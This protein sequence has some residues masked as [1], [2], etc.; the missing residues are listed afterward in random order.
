MQTSWFPRVAAAVR[1][2]WPI[3]VVII[4]IGLIATLVTLLSVHPKYAATTSIL[5]VAS[6]E[7]S[8]ALA[9]APKK[10]LASIDLPSLV[11]GPTVL[12]RVR[13]DIAES[14]PIQMLESRVHT[15]ISEDSAIM[16]VSYSANTAVKA[17]EGAN[18]F[19]TEITR[20]YR[21]LATTRFDS[22]ISDLRTQLTTRRAELGKLDGDIATISQAYPFVDTKSTSASESG[23]S[24]NQRLI[25]LQG[26]REALQA[27]IQAD[28]AV[29]R[30]SDRLIADA[31]PLAMRDVI[32]SD[33]VY[34]HIRD[35]YS[36]DAAELTRL[37]AFGSD[38]Y[39]GLVELRQ[40]V[41]REVQ[42]VESARQRAALAG[43]D[44]NAAFVAALDAKAKAETQVASD[45][46]KAAQEDQDLRL[47]QAQMGR[48]GVATTVTRLRRDHDVAEAAYSIIASRLAQSIADRAEAA[49]TGSV[50]VL[51]RAQ[52][53]TRPVLSGATIPCIALVFF[54]V[55][56]A[57][58][59]ALMIDSNE[60]W[61]HDNHTIETVY[62]APVVGSI[63]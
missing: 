53:A 7:G 24:V 28:M 61:L 38:R 42:Q 63:V 50:I 48:Q 37:S 27:T 8:N 58:T 20:F 6:P 46:A 3:I 36:R 54:S 11:T 43:P 44:S 4:G 62:G 60:K 25:T 51:E 18:A 40:T 35:Q 45:E 5:M 21:E 2:Q 15:R 52:F 10:P 47:L 23:S 49:S 19:G 57:L 31:H 59:L 17:I 55:W 56:L 13:T 26:D 9:T 22:L 34:S 33:T 41:A 1:H 14:T 32:Q 39:P 29:A 16:Q 30:S 12:S